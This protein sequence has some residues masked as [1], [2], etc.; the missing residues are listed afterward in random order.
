MNPRVLE[1]AGRLTL[2]GVPEGADALIL[3]EVARARLAEGLSGGILHVAR[4]D[5][6]LSALQDAL[7]FFAPEIEIITLPAWDCLPYDRI[8]PNPVLCARRMETLSLLAAP[9]QRMRVVLTT[10][11]A[12]SQRLPPRDVLRRNSFIAKIGDTVKIDDLVR[13]LSE[14]GYVRSSTV[15]EAGEFAVRGG[16]VDIFPAGAEEPIRL[17]FFGDSLDGI[18][19]FDPLNQL[20]TGKD[21][22]FRLV[23]VSEAPLD[24]AS[25]TRFRKGYRELFGAVTGGDPLYEAVSEG[26]KYQGMEHWLPLFYDG[27]DT[28]FDYLPDAFVSLDHLADE[29]FSSRHEMIE[30]YFRSRKEQADQKGANRYHPLAPKMLYLDPAEWN[31][32]LEKHDARAFNAYQVPESASVV[33]YGARKGRDFAP[34]RNAREVN[35][36]DALRQH[37]ITLV[38]SGKRV[39]IASYSEGSRERLGLVM[40]D[41]GMTGTKRIDHWSDIET[42]PKNIA[43]LSVLRLEHGFETADL[44]LVTEQDILG[45]RLI[46]KPKRSRRAENF[47]AEASS[48]NEGD[49]VVHLDHGIGRYEGLK[50]IEV[51]G[52]PHDC[53][54]LVYA[55]GDK[56]F[57][58]VENIDVLSRYGSEDAIVQLDKLGGQ[59]WQSR[60]AALKQRLKDMAEELMK[61]AAAR[62]LRVAPRLLPPQGLYDEFCARFP[63]QETDDQLRAIDDVTQ[64]LA[65]GKPMDRLICGDVGFGKTEVA[66][67]TAFIAALE[68]RQVALIA[69]TT[70]LVRQ[71]FKSFT[72]RFAGL[73]VRIEQLSRLVSAKDAKLIKENLASGHVDIVVGTHALLGKGIKFHDLGLLI[74]DEEQHFGVRHKERLKALREDVHVLTLTATPIPRTLQLAM[75]GMRGLSIIATPPVDRLAVRTFVM[76][77]DPLAIR[78]ALL[79]EHYRGGQSY[80]VCPRIADLAEIEAFLKESVPEVK[81]AVAHGQMPSE[82]LEDVMNAFYDNRFDVLLSTTII[83]SG[84][85]IP[86]VNTMIVHRADQ[87]GLAQLYQ[88]RGRIGRSKLRAYAYLTVPAGKTLTKTAEKRLKVLQSLD[89]LGAGFTLA[90]HDLDIRGAGNLLGEEQSGHIKEVGVELYQHLLEEAVVRARTEQTGGDTSNLEE[91]SASVNLGTAV[92]IPEDYVPDLGIRLGLYRRIAQLRTSQE[93]ESLAAEM[94]DRFGSLPAEVESLLKIVNIKQLCQQAGVAKLDAGPRG[95]TVAFRNASFNNPMGLVEFLS[96]QSGTA[97]LRPDHTLVLMRDWSEDKKRVRGAHELVKALAGIAAKAA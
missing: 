66:L 47:I 26:R 51:S 68:G 56:L 33:D 32:K 28:I 35:V 61:I 48:L 10:V 57:V 67:R 31:A 58:P 78:E 65:Q 59:A 97:K 52:A 95:A 72:E 23:P 81:F 93:I 63:Y 29:S 75:S 6:R 85:D 2:C 80:Y 21:K 87:F 3:A 8:S 20:T 39:L 17:D 70:L 27:M 90:S 11:N 83:E 19:R 37:L 50:T 13:F 43:G 74:I 49:Y 82:Q 34:E 92:L 22:K 79:R 16:L 4:D 14:N 55:G 69:P 1:M 45:D 96:K 60:K 30:D 40:A 18:R 73:P 5:A 25:I 88:L 84:I 38:D 91:W 9:G 64:D 24:E 12:A 44:A 53:V 7:E 42:L 89:E 94:I 41:H 62:E 46:R 36:Y 54:M 76:P 86:T 15:S 71:H 77:H